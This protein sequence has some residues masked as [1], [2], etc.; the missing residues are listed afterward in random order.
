MLCSNS[1]S[2]S[3]VPKVII[4]SVAK[5]INSSSLPLFIFYL[6]Q[7]AEIQIVIFILIPNCFLIFLYITILSR[8]KRQRLLK[9]QSLENVKN[10]KGHD[11]G[12]TFKVIKEALESLDYH[13][14]YEVLN[15]IDTREHTTE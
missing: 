13:I 4:W 3:P 7:I 12:R 8:L 1:L 5:T 11:E 15:S 9:R 10:L 6:F 14:K 2:I